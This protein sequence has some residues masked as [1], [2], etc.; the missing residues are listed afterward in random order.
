MRLKLKQVW[1]MM[2]LLFAFVALMSGQDAAKESVNVAGKWAVSIQGQRGSRTQ[3]MTI[4]QDG[5]KISGSIQ[6]I[7]ATRNFRG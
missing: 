2:M 6:G 3:N 5:T 1:L 7:A 4:Q